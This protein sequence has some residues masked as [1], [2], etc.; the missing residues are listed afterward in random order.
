MNSVSSSLV[1]GWNRLESGLESVTGFLETQLAWSYYFQLAKSFAPISTI[2]G[3]AQFPLPLLP[4]VRLPC[5]GQT[6]ALSSGT[7]SGLLPVAPRFY[8]CAIPTEREDTPN[9]LRYRLEGPE[10]Q[11]IAQEEAAK[12]SKILSFS[13]EKE[14]PGGTWW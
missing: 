9:S 10:T 5:L 4:W 8:L 14:S 12:Y 7:F 13:G 1:G 2:S 3:T 11:S 6:R